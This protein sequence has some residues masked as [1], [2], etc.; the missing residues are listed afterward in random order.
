MVRFSFCK[1]LLK[2]GKA[3]F[4]AT[5]LANAHGRLL[6]VLRYLNRI[7]ELSDGTDMFPVNFVKIIHPLP[8]TD[9]QC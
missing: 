1:K 5:L 9:S 3:L 4:K 8:T 6:G 2:A 7:S